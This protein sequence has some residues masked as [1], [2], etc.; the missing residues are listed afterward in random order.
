MR[1]NRVIRSTS[2]TEGQLH[3]CPV[4]AEVVVVD[5]RSQ[6]HRS[7]LSRVYYFLFLY[8][9]DLRIDDSPRVADSAGRLP[10]VDDLQQGLHPARHHNDLFLPDSVNT[11]DA[12]KLPRA[13]DDRS[14]R[15]RVSENQS[16]EL[17][18]LPAGRNV[19][20]LRVARR[21]R[22]HWL[23]LLHAFQYD[24]FKLL[25]RRHRPWEFLSTASPR[26]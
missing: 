23:D 16:V 15:S 8:R 17:V 20:D 24:F 21:R 18:H 25:C 11:G 4:R 3:Q 19:N 13:D 22:R 26:S 5:Q 9:R 14:E 10:S 7:A 1:A 6:A 2:S 12:G